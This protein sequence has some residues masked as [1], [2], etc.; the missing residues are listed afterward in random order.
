M[1]TETS[2]VSA[3]TPVANSMCLWC[4]R[5]NGLTT[6]PAWAM[7]FVV[8]IF[9]TTRLKEEEVVSTMGNKKVGICGVM[10]GSRSYAY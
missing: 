1:F 10:E 7:Y 5:I 8:I 9:D 4:G 2:E 3:I 6:L